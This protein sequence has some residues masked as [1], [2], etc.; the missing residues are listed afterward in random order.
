[1]VT[2][3]FGVEMLFANLKL[4]GPGTKKP[5]PLT[6]EEFLRRFSLHVMPE[7]YVRIR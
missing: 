4:P 2:F 3:V 5:V 1:V 6:G 7:G